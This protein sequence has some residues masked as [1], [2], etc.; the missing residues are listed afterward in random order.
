MV[1]QPDRRLGA[2]PGDYAHRAVPG[3]QNRVSPRS[4]HRSAAEVTISP[5]RSVFPSRRRACLDQV[6]DAV[7]GPH[8]AAVSKTGIRRNRLLAAKACWPAGCGGTPVAARQTTKFA[9]GNR[10]R[11]ISTSATT[12]P[13]VRS[14]R[15]ARVIAPSYGRFA[16]AGDLAIAKACCPDMLLAD[17]PTAV[18]DTSVQSCCA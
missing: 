8:E 10:R 6:K 16:A 17:G 3:G 5:I 12:K 1:V 13:S 18:M 15:S 7:D 9:G 11:A 2:V 4:V 14:H